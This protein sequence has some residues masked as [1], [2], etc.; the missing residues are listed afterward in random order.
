MFAN[1]AM[2]SITSTGT[3]TFSLNSVGVGSWK[4]WRSKKPTGSLVYY[5]A[6]DEDGV[7][8]EFGYGTLTHGTPDTITRNLLDPTDSS[9][10]SLIDWQVATHG[11]VYVQSVP[12]SQAM[13]G[14]HDATAGYFFPA[15]R[16]LYT[17]KGANSYTL[18]A[19]DIGGRFSF[20]NSAAA[21]TATLPAGS[22]VG[23]GY[24]VDLLGLGEL[25]ALI[26]APDGSDAI[27][28]GANGES[29]SVW[30]KKTVT[31]RW[32]GDKW[33]TNL[34]GTWRSLGI[35]NPNGASSIDFTGIPSYINHI[36]ILGQ[37]KVNTNA[38]NL[39]LRTYGAD[40]ALDIGGSDY[41]YV[42]VTGGTAPT[43]PATA[44]AS[45][46]SSMLLAGSVS[47]SSQQS[48]GFSILA[49]NIQAA[50]YTPFQWKAWFLNSGGAEFF[51]V[52]GGGVRA[53][54][55]R[56]TGVRILADTGNLGNGADRV[57]IFGCE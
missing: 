22:S 11:T 23:I 25:F 50:K 14:R 29:V 16:R 47:S 51:N 41:A 1:K 34:P 56:I 36:H 35:A 54:N 12:I 38:V 31:I 19:N 30:G 48:A 15:G 4:S 46:A 43:S 49:E 45:S 28:F 8:W 37:C 55:D 32:D 42:D 17:A 2:Q 5:Y 24:S 44:A 21:R 26:I 18:T 6:E 33:R 27:D 40:G 39:L 10:G 13:E 20:D 9:T 3:G 7:D 52:D 53:E 57:E